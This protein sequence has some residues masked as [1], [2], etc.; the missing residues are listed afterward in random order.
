[1]LTILQGNCL[2]KLRELPDASVQ[3]CV[4]SPPYWGL[5]DYKSEGMIGLEPS[6]GEWLKKIIEVFGEVRRVLRDDGTLWC[7]MGDCYNSGASGAQG[8]TGQMKNRTVTRHR[9]EGIVR[10]VETLKRK[11]MVG[12][13]WRLAFALQDAGWYLRRDIIWH[14]PN[15]MPE[16]VYDR[17]TTSHEY[18]F[19]LSK[20]PK[21]FYNAR[22]A[23]EAVTGNT[24]ARGHGVNQKIKMPDGWDTG[25]GAH[26]TIHRNGRQIGKTRPRQNTSFSSAVAGAVDDRNWRSVWTI[27]TEKYSGD[28]FATF[29]Q[30]LAQRCIIA[31][32]KFNDIVLDPF[33]GSG[34]T[35]KVAL[36]LGRQAILCELNPEYVKLIRQR[37]ETTVGLPFA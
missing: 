18:I 8:D 29:P 6:L 15:P 4:T 36:E 26:G 21:Y 7:N 11:D 1:M 16:T 33:A 14:K 28:H 5:R 24:H 35:G 23:R 30:A 25:E 9:I 32:T 3:C 27:P 22:E 2:E 37:C 20:S 34:T 17:P 31:G 10:A 13:P 12:Q 19:L